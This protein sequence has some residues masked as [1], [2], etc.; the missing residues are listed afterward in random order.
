MVER[1]C[2]KTMIENAMREHGETWADV[3]ANTLTEE[4]MGE[5]F[6]AG[7]GAT[8]G[9]PFTVWTK[10]H[11]YFPC[12]YDGMEWVGSVSRH[13]DGRPTEHMGN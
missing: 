2:W 11:V 12:T 1:D 8:E 13:P 6:Y 10:G 5:M 4:E 3:E 7:Y 9:R